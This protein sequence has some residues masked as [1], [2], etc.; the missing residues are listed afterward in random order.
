M[1]RLVGKDISGAAERQAGTGER[2]QD[3]TSL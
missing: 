3:R 2:K 1:S